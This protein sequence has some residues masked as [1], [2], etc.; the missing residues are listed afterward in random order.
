M[1]VQSGVDGAIIAKLFE[2][3]I[4]GQY[5]NVVLVAG[6]G[7]LAPVLDTLNGPL[8]A[9]L[10][11]GKRPPAM[12]CFVSRASASREFGT[13]NRLGGRAPIFLDEPQQHSLGNQPISFPEAA[14][15][16][17]G[18]A[19]GPAL[20]HPPA[21]RVPAAANR[22]VEQGRKPRPKKQPVAKKPA[23]KYQPQ[24]PLDFI[25]KYAA[26]CW[27]VNLRPDDPHP[28]IPGVRYCKRSP[29][30]WFAECDS[31]ATA[32][33][34]AFQLRQPVDC[35]KRV[36]TLRFRRSDSVEAIRSV[37]VPHI[38]S[39]GL[40]S[41]GPFLFFQTEEGLAMAKASLAQQGITPYKFAACYRRVMDGKKTQYVYLGLQTVA[42][43][44]KP[45]QDGNEQNF[46]DEEEE[47]SEEESDEN[48]ESQPKD[49][50]GQARDAPRVDLVGL[51]TACWVGAVCQCDA[52]SEAL[53][54][55]DGSS[56]QSFAD[57]LV[58]HGESKLSQYLS[59][60]DRDSACGSEKSVQRVGV[61]KPA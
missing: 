22:P 10:G 1:W 60:A 8:R 6:D 36:F 27:Q 40:A 49:E 61:W 21:A 26:T 2:C 37:G 35:I 50:P 11:N 18:G 58:Q 52:V 51:A 29:T 45:A 23:E 4:C 12:V 28:P 46:D 32:T 16:G 34:F 33:Q 3:Y 31:E 43:V 13:N 48:D 54:D 55:D 53:A 59:W 5:E 19:Q 20:Q 38:F 24:L 30:L 41:Q 9:A 17:R 14:L 7:D 44:L 39:P 47:S 56:M 57:F 25:E 15:F 42:N